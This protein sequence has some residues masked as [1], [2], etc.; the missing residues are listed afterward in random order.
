MAA[1]E[2]CLAAAMDD[3]GPVGGEGAEALYRQ[4]SS[5]SASERTSAG[6][7]HRVSVGGEHVPRTRLPP[8]SRL[9]VTL[10]SAGLLIA[11][12]WIQAARAGLG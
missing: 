9:L 12:E 5:G 10:C 7:C 1:S 3:S 11:G 4:L 8:A 6:G 2:H